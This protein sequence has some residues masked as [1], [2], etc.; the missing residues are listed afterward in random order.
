M[1]TGHRA[2]EPASFSG[3]PLSSRINSRPNDS[4]TYFITAKLRPND[5]LIFRAWSVFCAPKPWLII[6]CESPRRRKSRFPYERSASNSLMK[7]FNDQP[8]SHRGKLM[9]KL[10][11]W[12]IFTTFI[13][14]ASSGDVLTSFWWYHAPRDIFCLIYCWACWKWK[15]FIIFKCCRLEKL[16]FSKLC[17]FNRQACAII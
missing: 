8:R 5:L 11:N 4:A 13:Y 9:R 1:I 12:E 3:P 10:R 17:L 2:S 7:K 15:L 16:N 14:G 6:K